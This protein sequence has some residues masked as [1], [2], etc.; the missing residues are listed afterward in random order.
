MNKILLIVA[1]IIGV[2]VVTCPKK[3]DHK[4]KLMEE[5]NTL[6]D[7]ELTK[8][9]DTD[10]AKA[11]A[12]LGSAFG[13]SVVSYMMDGRLSVDNYFVCS[14]GKLTFD[15]ETTIVSV[16]AFNHIFTDVSNRIRKAIEEMEQSGL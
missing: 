16:G 2:S 11:L 10:E 5:V 4:E 1:M 14:V 12:I 9:M 13:S 8:K 15:G 6:L 7:S 3:E